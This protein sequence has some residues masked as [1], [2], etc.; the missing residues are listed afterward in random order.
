M[1]KFNFKILFVLGAALVMNACDTSRDINGDLLVGVDYDGTEL[2]DTGG[3]N[4]TA[5]KKIKKIVDTNVDGETMTTEYT[6]NGSKL[7]GVTAKSTEG[8]DATYTLVYD[9][10][11]LTKVTLNQIEEGEKLD[12]KFDL[13]YTGDKLVSCTGVATSGGEQVHVANTIFSYS[14]S[15]ISN[16]KTTYQAGTTE[17]GKLETLI[18][19]AS[20]NINKFNITM[21][22]MGIPIVTEN[23]PSNYDDKKN[24]FAA[25]PEAF[26]VFSLNFMFGS[27]P[28]AVLSKNNYRTLKSVVMG[29]T[30]TISVN[31]EYNADGYPVSGTRS[32]G[33]KITFQYY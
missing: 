23:T 16:V 10:D 7:V 27:S 2:P 18:G 20:G 22:S 30:M 4:E 26:K 21:T 14:A 24:P 5:V 11:V 33:G 25:F 6:Y 17:I 19:F 9:G 29:Q 3:D 8:D 12:T 31:Y 32:D 28:I 13:N 15:G 1:M